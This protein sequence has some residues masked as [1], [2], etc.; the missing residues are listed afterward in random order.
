MYCLDVDIE[1]LELNWISIPNQTSIGNGLQN[2]FYCFDAAD[3]ASWNLMTWQ[4][5]IHVWMVHTMGLANTHLISPPHLQSS[6]QR[7]SHHRQ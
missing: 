6:P 7:S 5:P 1:L 3:I 2:Q 4:I